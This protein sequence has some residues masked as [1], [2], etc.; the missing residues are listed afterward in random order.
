MLGVGAH[1][2]GCALLAAGCAPDHVHVLVRVAPIVALAYLVQRLKGG[3]AYESNHGA[4]LSPRL[5][6]QAGYWAESV[7]PGDLEALTRYLR[8]QRQHHESGKAPEPWEV[9]DK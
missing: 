3:S 9:D 5:A 7:S 2:V 6:W 4:L 8:S 1:S